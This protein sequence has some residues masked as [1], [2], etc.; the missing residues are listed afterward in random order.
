ME[1]SNDYIKQHPLFR[2][3]DIVIVDKKKKKKKGLE[4]EINLINRFKQNE[5]LIYLYKGDEKKY[6]SLLK[7]RNFF[8][9]DYTIIP[10]QLPKN[11]AETIHLIYLLINQKN[12]SYLKLLNSWSSTNKRLQNYTI[13]HGKYN[14]IQQLQKKGKLITFGKNAIY[15]LWKEGKGKEKK[16]SKGELDQVIAMVEED[17][18]NSSPIIVQELMSG[19]RRFYHS[20]EKM[21]NLADTASIHVS[22]LR[23]IRGDD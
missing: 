4:T 10:F 7:V 12:E 16:I 21:E 3:H 9:P 13:L 14:K 2:M 22:L 17:S 18:K 1:H 19:D 15:T 23:H 6:E 11:D 8:L 20:F 5:K